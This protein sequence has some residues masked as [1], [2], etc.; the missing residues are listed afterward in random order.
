MHEVSVDVGFDVLSENRRLA[1]ENRRLFDEAGVVVFNVMGAI[2][3]GKTAL[4]EETVKKLDV[5]C[6]VIAGDVVA[7]V[8]A[9]RFRKLGVPVLALNTGRE[10]HLD[11]YLLRRH[12]QGFP[13]ENLDVVFVENVGNLICPAD[14]PL[15]E[16]VRV[17][18][19]SVSEGDDIVVKHPLIFRECDCVV[20]NKIDIA[21][22]VG[23]DA[24]RMAED[25]RRF[26]PR[27]AVVKMS[28]KS[29]AGFGDWF[30]FVLTK[31]KYH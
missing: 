31:L 2:G 16:H 27:V 10:C 15:G 26:N 13:L 23:A 5:R 30:D 17:V 4:I 20:V 19:V 25:A 6:G 8:D 21:E 7:E 28:V 1:G 11:A 24:D 12:L 29:G 18:V 14:F 22:A 9:S 3:S